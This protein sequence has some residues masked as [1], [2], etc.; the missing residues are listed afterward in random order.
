LVG[1]LGQQFQLVMPG[2]AAGL[3][4]PQP[5]AVAL[6]GHGVVEPLGLE[7]RPLREPTGLELA[8]SQASQISVSPS[9]NLRD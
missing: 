2:E 1:Y 7:E 8:M 3:G 9:Q 5:V 4:Q 6:A